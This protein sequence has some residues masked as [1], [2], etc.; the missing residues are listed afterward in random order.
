MGQPV[1]G[2]GGEARDALRSLGRRTDP[3]RA[4]SRFRAREE[5]GRGR[6]RGRDD[7]HHGCDIVAIASWVEWRPG[8]RSPWARVSKCARRASARSFSL[9]G[10]VNEKNA[11]L[12]RRIPSTRQEFTITDARQD[13]CVF[14]VV[15]NLVVG[16]LRARRGTR[17]TP[18]RSPRTARSRDAARL[19]I[20]RRAVHRSSETASSS[21]AIA[22]PI[23]RERVSNVMKGAQL[24][25]LA[26]PPSS[27]SAPR[28]SAGL[29]DRI[30]DAA[31]A[32]RRA[33]LATSDFASGSASRNEKAE[34]S[35]SAKASPRRRASAPA[36]R[37]SRGS[38]A[39]SSRRRWSSCARRRNPASAG[40]APRRFRRC[41]STSKAR[42]FARSPRFPVRPSARRV[43]LEG[44]RHSVFESP[45]LSRFEQP[46]SRHDPAYEVRV[47]F[48]KYQ[49]AHARIAASPPSTRS[50]TA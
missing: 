27:S 11:E 9:L 13:F 37:L 23:R 15:R 28:R 46:L 30:L 10:V 50:R 38:A 29:A 49:S 36:S 35:E 48:L 44:R 6:A 47:V 24:C 5:A 8:T 31:R 40:R 25:P 20:A 19:S 43:S 42:P 41:R 2:A 39:A 26:S 7:A 16:P 22:R 21:D 34:S 3:S 14:G 1:E 32:T 12:R 45:D 33:Q 17:R 4:P 18:P